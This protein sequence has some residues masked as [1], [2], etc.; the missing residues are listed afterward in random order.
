MD[1]NHISIIVNSEQNH[2][3][4]LKSN[5]VETKDGK[6][7]EDEHDIEA[8][9]T[10]KSFENL[11][12][13][14]TEVK[15]CSDK[16]L[17]FEQI[18]SAFVE[19]ENKGNLKWYDENKYRV[20]FCR[21]AWLGEGQWQISSLR[22]LGLYQT[23]DMHQHNNYI[24]FSSR[25]SQTTARFYPLVMIEDME[26][27]E[28]HFFEMSSSSGWYIEICIEYNEKGEETLFVFLS[29]SCEKN[30]GWYKVLKPNEAYRTE[31]AIF[32]TVKGGFEDAA[33]ALTEYKRGGTRIDAMPV[34]FNDYMNCC[35][36]MP[37]IEKEK[38]LI[39]AAA[40][41][42][43]EIFCFD[44]GWQKTAF[45][46]SVRYIGDW[47]IARERFAP[48]TFQYLID[49]AK[50][51][52]LIVGAWL[53][54][55]GVHNETEAYGKHG[56]AILKRRG[57][58]IG[59]PK[60]FFDFRN[61][62][63]KDKIEKV[64]DKLYGM[65]I[66]YIKND[67]NQTIGIG[68]DGDSSLS[69]TLRQNQEAFLAFIEYIEGKYPDLI[70][71]NCGSGGMR[72]DNETLSRFHLQSVSD[73]EV[74]T[75][76]P[77][78]LSGIAACLPPEKSGIWSYPYPV[79]Y[80]DRFEYKIYEE[81]YS[82]GKQTAFNMVSSMLGLI[83]LS[84]RIDESDEYNKHLIKNA[85]SIY[86]SIRDDYK[87]S[88]PIYPTGT[89]RIGDSGIFTYGLLNKEKKTAYIAVWKI[90]TAESKKEFDLSGY[91]TVK[92]V[93]K[94]Y[95]DKF[96]AEKCGNS[97]IAEFTGGDCAMLLKVSFG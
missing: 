46:E 85:I 54:I 14:C 41:V 63:I 75:C 79:R 58:N 45:D 52:G 7:F 8:A 42:G 30:D 66:R 92:A 1:K 10:E 47:D 64:F 48:E 13:V 37:T 94:L 39:D 22:D 56:D 77:S 55:E 69:E 15:N 17:E 96:A 59:S 24:A 43:A 28:I 21:S 80:E 71:E 36:A 93:E 91:G 19:I 82:D 26:C 95:P 83:M 65:G 74:Y 4:C 57:N 9:I 29:G 33:A 81:D 68:A 44:S 70:I 89:F 72:C 87:S 25:G 27:G 12:E 53:E 86:K 2:L 5:F 16:E 40:E 97:V 73:Q 84:G 11:K 51:K 32:G 23:Y 3:S 20:H 61:E 38:K 90:K 49:Y 34:I 88:F 67:Y 35:W 50:S 60:S 78:I 62:A 6:Y 18:S 31:K 76:N